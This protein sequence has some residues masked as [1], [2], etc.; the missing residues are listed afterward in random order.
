MQHASPHIVGTGRLQRCA[1]AVTP[2]KHTVV[3][4]GRQLMRLLGLLLLSY[5]AATTVQADVTAPNGR[6]IDCYCTDKSGS[7][8]ELGEFI[9]LQVDGRMFTAQCQMSLNVPMWREVQKGCLA[10]EADPAPGLSVA[11]APLPRI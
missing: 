3:P 8:I 5:A 2:P 1:L 11:T 7:R 4:P 10:A 6:T 9:C